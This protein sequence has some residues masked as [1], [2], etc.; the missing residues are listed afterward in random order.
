MDILESFAHFWGSDG[1]VGKVCLF[2]ICLGGSDRHFL[3]F[4]SF[5]NLCS[6]SLLVKAAT[7][8]IETHR[9]SC[10]WYIGCIYTIYVCLNT[11]QR[12]QKFHSHTV[13]IVFWRCLK[14]GEISSVLA[15]TDCL[16]SNPERALLSP[17]NTWVLLFYLIL[18]YL[19]FSKKHDW[20]KDMIFQNKI[21][22]Y[23]TSFQ[24]R[25]EF[26]FICKHLVVFTLLLITSCH[27][28]LFIS[29]ISLETIWLLLF[30]IYVLLSFGHR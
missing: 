22:L 16:K 20:I 15:F 12:S 29:I 11:I 27:S 7:L 3:E 21:W 28:F 5:G 9:S 23:A 19:I 10:H 25:A 4:C 2:F 26:W 24:L 1:H 14:I 13:A 30:S 6:E 18:S 17:V 8:L